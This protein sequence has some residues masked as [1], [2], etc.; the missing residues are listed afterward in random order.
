MDANTEIIDFFLRDDNATN[1]T[2]TPSIISKIHFCQ[3]IVYREAGDTRIRF[4]DLLILAPNLLFFFFLLWRFKRT[5]Q[6]LKTTHSLIIF[7]FYLLIC[8]NVIV[9]IARCL[10]SMSV[11][12]ASSVG[13]TADQVFWVIV[14]FFLLSTEIS[15]LVFALVFGHLDSRKS[16]RR[17]M[18]VT[19]SV[20]LTYSICQG[21]L[22][23]I[24]PDEK[25]YIA[26]K[27][28]HLFSHGGMVFWFFTC[29]II[30]IVYLIIFILPW[31]PCG[32]RLQL[33]AKRSFYV[34]TI[35]L[36]L[37]NILQ[38]TGSGLYYKNTIEGLCIVDITTYLYFTFFTPL[39][40]WTFLAGF[41][42][43]AK[44]QILF[45]YKPQIDDGL[46]DTIV[47]TVSATGVVRLP[48]QLSCS[49][50]RTDN[51]DFVY[52]QPP[53]IGGPSENAHS[54][55][56]ESSSFSPDSIESCIV[57]ANN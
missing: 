11:N 7:T 34:Y 25:F 26:E 1:V 18:M 28:F 36:S 12:A 33:P 30:G 31:T 29:L 56:Y 6:R 47:G 21:T 51:S 44:S 46:D 52:Q 17:V 23:L 54:S 45:S 48:H 3:W 13:G 42:S 38:A 24:A 9:S 39:V 37:L 20:S 16:I 14:R 10:I 22:E 27:G 55:K 53:Q 57:V 35:T 15:V 41:L 49:S 8:I 50:I 43:S 19:C 2:E 32:K 40:Y 4:W 5:R